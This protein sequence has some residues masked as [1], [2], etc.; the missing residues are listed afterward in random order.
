MK[1]EVADSQVQFL[2]RRFIPR[3][4]SRGSARSLTP[5]SC[6]GG[7]EASRRGLAFSKAA[8]SGWE[9]QEL[10]AAT[11]GGREKSGPKTAVAKHGSRVG[12]RARRESTG[13]VGN[14]I[15]TEPASAI[16]FRDLKPIS[17]SQDGVPMTT[18]VGSVR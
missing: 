18:D 10:G 9:G 6:S 2:C 5:I 13:P 3:E 14:K 7:R 17:G 8:G 1:S 16:Y 12:R 15:P 11:P 4:R